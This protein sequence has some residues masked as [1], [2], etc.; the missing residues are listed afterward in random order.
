MEILLGE[1]KNYWSGV[2]GVVWVVRW[3]NF[4]DL[5]LELFGIEILNLIRGQSFF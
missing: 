2:G 5:N 1:I 3:E 4:W